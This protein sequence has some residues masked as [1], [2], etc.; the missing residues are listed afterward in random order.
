MASSTTGA[1]GLPASAQPLGWRHLV[2]GIGLSVAVAACSAAGTA[3]PFASVAGA[4]ATPASSATPTA[5]PTDTPTPAVSPTDTPAPTPTPAPTAAP[6][7]TPKPAPKVTP[8]PPLAIGL[9]TGG[10][11][12]LTLDYWIGSSGNP[13]YAHVYVTNVSSASCTMRGTARSQIVDG[14][15][16]VIVDS[17]T[18]GSE[19][20][21]SDPAYTVAPNG[22]VYSI[23][24]WDNW[25]KSSPKQK[26]T[27]AVYQPFG[28]GHYQAKAPGNAPIANCY[29]S[30][31]KSTVTATPWTP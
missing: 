24:E 14:S 22:V 3:A 11:L 21:T 12:K 9:C 19:I 7:A 1:T 30:S 17:G 2:L 25:C 23:I 10:Q 13:S 4:S 15:G 8:L 6:K 26:V 20:K 5:S 18:G 27:V 29:A 16:H 28:L 31:S